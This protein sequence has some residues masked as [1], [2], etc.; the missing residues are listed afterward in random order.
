MNHALQEHL[1]VIIAHV[2]CPKGF[3]KCAAV[4]K[5]K[6]FIKDYFTCTG[7]NPACC[8]HSLSYGYSYYCL[9]PW[10]NCVAK[11]LFNECNA[12][13]LIPLPGRDALTAD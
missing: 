9:C 6:P 10:L 5:T 2:P 12:S 3:N 8:H 7:A 11:E 4:F 1:H 13:G